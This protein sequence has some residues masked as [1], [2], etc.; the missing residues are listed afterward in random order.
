MLRRESSTASARTPASRY[1]ALW[2]VIVEKHWLSAIIDGT[3]VYER[4]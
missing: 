1:P 4:Q 2:D 3:P